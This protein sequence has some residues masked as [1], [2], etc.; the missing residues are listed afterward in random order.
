MPNNE[1]AYEEL[2]EAHYPMPLSYKLIPVVVAVMLA[3][4]LIW[5]EVRVWKTDSP[6]PSEKVSINDASKFLDQLSVRKRLN[7]PRRFL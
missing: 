6:I 4:A 2:V 3:A 5:G 7:E 1:I